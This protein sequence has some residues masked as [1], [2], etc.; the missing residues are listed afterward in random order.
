M[1]GRIEA[2][3]ANTAAANI[4]LDH[5]R[6][7]HSARCIGTL[8]GMINYDRARVG[9]AERF[10]ERK[11]Q[12]LRRFVAKSFAAVDDADAHA[13]EMREVAK[14]VKN[15]VSV[16]ARPSRRTH[17]IENQAELLSTIGRDVEVVTR[18]V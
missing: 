3:Y 14:R 2:H 13:L 12:G 7:A 4:G 8:A 18:G 11:L 5:H 6:E 17:A 15:G 16:T 10:E 9:K 1:L